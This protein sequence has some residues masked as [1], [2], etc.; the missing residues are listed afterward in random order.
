MFIADDQP[1][2]RSAMRLVVG[3]LVGYRVAGEAADISQMLALVAAEPPDV[4]LLDWEL[5]GGFP[6]DSRM[7]AE[8]RAN[9]SGLRVVV[10]SARDGSRIEAIDG[11]ADAFVSKGDS[12]RR[13]IEVLD[14]L[15]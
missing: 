7:L 15:W 13:L 10:M 14:E 9:A 4:V 11:G 12:P 3:Q 6:A 2:V 1:E 8:L 5:P